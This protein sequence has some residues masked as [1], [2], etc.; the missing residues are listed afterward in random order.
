MTGL[1]IAGIATYLPEKILT[2]EAAAA[3]TGLSA[4]IRKTKLGINSVRIAAADETPSE[5][6]TR[7][8]QILCQRDGLDPQTFEFLIL[9]TQNPD[10]RLPT[11]ACIVQ[12]KAGLSRQIFAYD[13]NQGCSGFV[14]ALAQAHGLI[15]SGL[16][17]QGLIVTTEVYNRII[18]PSDKDTFGLFGDAACAIAVTSAAETPQEGTR[19]FFFGT[20]G[21]GAGHLIQRTG[22]SAAETG[23]A[24]DAFLYMNGRAIFEFVVRNIPSE[25]DRFLASQ[26]LTKNSIDQ[27][28]FH[29]ANRFM[30]GRLVQQMGLSEEAAFFDISDIGNTVSCSIPIALERLTATATFRGGRTL[31][32]GFGVGLSWAGCIYDFPR[33]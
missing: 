20:D 11:T 15:K 12:A 18:D 21:S 26:N 6:A 23:V 24:R 16:F 32:C 31:L 5:M 30:N 3:S 1:R 4:E 9:V 14:V 2:S 7:A 10:Y 33:N 8:I 28:V 19:G 29:Q 22:G 17:R 13:I 25:I 27:W